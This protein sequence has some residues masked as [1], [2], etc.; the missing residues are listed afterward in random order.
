[1]NRFR[2]LLL[3]AVAVLLAAPLAAQ[4][5]DFTRYVAI[6]DSLS[7]G[8]SDGGLAER[9]QRYSIP[10]QI[11]AATHNGSFSGF[12]QPLVSNPGIPAQLQLVSIVPN[13][14]ISQKPG[15]GAP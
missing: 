6:G 5:L 7:A 4:T 12:E 1:M 9:T 13:V 14:V 3:L 11:Y 8:Y 2:P 10:A 15:Q